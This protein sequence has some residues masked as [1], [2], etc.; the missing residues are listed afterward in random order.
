MDSR[1]GSQFPNATTSKIVTSGVWRHR[2]TWCHRR[3]H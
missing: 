2:V 3:R 1:N